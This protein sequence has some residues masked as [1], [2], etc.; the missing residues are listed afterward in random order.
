LYD[1]SRLTR[2]GSRHGSTIRSD[3]LKVRVVILS[4][5]D[6]VPDG[7]FQDVMQSIIDTQ[8]HLYSR[9]LSG[10]VTRGIVQGVLRGDSAHHGLVPLGIDRLYVR[11]DG[12]PFYRLRYPGHGVRQLFEESTG[13]LIR[14]FYPKVDRNTAYRTMAGEKVLVVPGD[15]YVV[16]VIREAFR[17]RYVDKYGYRRI[18]QYIVKMG[19]KPLMKAKWRDSVVRNILLNP[20]YLGWGYFLQSESGLFHIGDPNQ[21]RKRALNQAEFEDADRNT[22]PHKPRHVSEMIPLKFP[23]MQGFITD[24]V[25]RERAEAAIKAYFE[26]RHIRGT[27]CQLQ[28]PN[29]RPDTRYILRGLLRDPAQ[30]S[31]YTGRTTGKNATVRYYQLRGVYDF[32]DAGSPARRLLP[33][34]P[35][36]RL[37]LHLLHY[38]LSSSDRVNTA[39]RTYVQKALSREHASRDREALVAETEE[40]KEKF[41]AMMVTLS[42]KQLREQKPLL[43]NMQARRDEIERALAAM[44]CG[45]LS[46]D[47]DGIV[48]RMLAILGQ[49]DAEMDGP[50]YEKLRHLVCSLCPKF[51]LNILTREGLLEV[52]LPE[53]ALFRSGQGLEQMCET[54]NEVHSVGHS[55]HH[56]SRDLKL[57]TYSITF[58]SPDANRKPWLGEY[59]WSEVQ[60]TTTPTPTDVEGRAAYAARPLGRFQHFS[61]PEETKCHSRPTTGRCASA[62]GPSPSWTVFR[63]T[64]TT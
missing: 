60:P 43:D 46:A 31:M 7:D 59:V 30:D 57:A 36:E 12:T 11:A 39:V 22:V 25:V 16:D 15:P 56:F 63:A 58:I 28:N 53:L 51:E 32:T 45:Q 44:P 52:A 27:P 34:E 3:F 50:A 48:T 6:P 9:K 19:I 49:P 40:I 64:W 20:I 8:N 13:K 1:S 38:T 35:L 61:I 18:R 10:F 41:S 37:V 4:V 33:A 23:H 47:V 24:P 26:T 62:S 55:A 42:A 5:M 17:L 29:R 2:G 21:P 14:E 54:Y